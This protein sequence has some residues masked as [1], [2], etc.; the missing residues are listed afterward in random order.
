MSVTGREMY[1]LNGSFVAVALRS[2]E[3]LEGHVLQVSAEGLYLTPKTR[4]PVPVRI[5]PFDGIQSIER[6]KERM[7]PGA[8]TL[9]WTSKNIGATEL[10][11]CCERLEQA[12]RQRGVD[13][14]IARWLVLRIEFLLGAVLQ[15]ELLDQAA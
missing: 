1:G 2:G 14:Q 4:I 8:R 5:L 12:V 15:T 9:M 3:R 6:Q 7:S 10:C 13:P 11:E